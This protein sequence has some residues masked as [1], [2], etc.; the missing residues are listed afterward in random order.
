VS[1]PIKAHSIV[2]ID[3]EEQPPEGGD[4]IVKYTSAHVD[5]GESEFI[6][7]SY[8]SCLNKPET[9]EELRRILHEHLASLPAQGQ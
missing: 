3:G 2:A 8:H 9:I 7:R 5:Y 6:V 1:P 4:G